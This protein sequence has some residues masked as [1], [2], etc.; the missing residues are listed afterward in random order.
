MSV[1]YGGRLGAILDK[2]P[3]HSCEV[4]ESKQI[5]IVCYLEG[6]PEYKCRKCNHRFT[7]SFNDEGVVYDNTWGV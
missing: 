2:Y 3:E 1:G 6:E 5:Q 7:L 4:C